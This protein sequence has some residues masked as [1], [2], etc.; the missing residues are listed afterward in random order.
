MPFI[1]INFLLKIYG[2]NHL[3][4]LRFK[5]IWKSNT[6]IIKLMYLPP[7]LKSLMLWTTKFSYLLNSK[8]HGD[9]HKKQEKMDMCASVLDFT[10]NLTFFF[11]YSTRIVSLSS[12]WNHLK[13]LKIAVIIQISR[14]WRKVDYLIGNEYP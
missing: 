12:L 4:P 8:H 10:L 9:V 5:L 11:Q 7:F 13:N 2:K 14:E 1:Y 3:C 6:T